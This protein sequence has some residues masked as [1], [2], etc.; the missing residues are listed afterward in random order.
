MFQ[1]SSLLKI[2]LLSF[3]LLTIPL[4]LAVERQ[5]QVS[6]IPDLIAVSDPGNVPDS[7]G[8]GSV[9]GSFLLSKCQI[10]VDQW[11]CF[12]NSVYVDP[13]DK[14]D[15]R[16]LYHPEMFDDKNPSSL[17]QV[18]ITKTTNK[19]GSQQKW[20]YSPR[21]VKSGFFWTTVTNYGSSPI[22][23]IPLDD[24]KRYCNWCEHGSPHAATLEEALDVTENG[25]YDFTDG[26]EGELV[27][28]A[29]CM[30]SDPMQGDGGMKIAALSDQGKEAPLSNLGVNEQTTLSTIRPAHKNS[31][32]LFL[33]S[34]KDTA[35]A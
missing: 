24:E 20:T 28:E 30:G 1:Q 7:F 12:M 8:Y 27:N 35:S 26:K 25:V 33:E 11:A 22:T 13:E 2:V 32:N 9:S 21:S 34:L 10:T 17:L 15:F 16:G 23:N 3:L 5:D 31:S 6:L 29:L 14:N 4:A 18:S 19:P